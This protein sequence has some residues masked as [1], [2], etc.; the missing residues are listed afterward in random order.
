MFF[1]INLLQKRTYPELYSLL[2]N[3]IHKR[4]ITAPT[5]TCIHE[6][7]LPQQEVIQINW[8]VSFELP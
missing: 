5:P 2:E 1:A 8:R 4:L 3:L 6:P 7:A